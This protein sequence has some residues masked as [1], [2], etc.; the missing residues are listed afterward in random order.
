[1]SK[2]YRLIIFLA[3]SAIFFILFFYQ[4]RISHNIWESLR[5]PSLLFMIYLLLVFIL[6]VVSAITDLKKYS[7]GLDFPADMSEFPSL[8]V[9]IPARNEELNIRRCLES[10]AK[11]EYPN[12]EIIVVDDNSTDRT[13]E[14]I[15]ERAKD[16]NRIKAI[17]AGKLPQGWL[18]KLNALH[19]GIS[20][21]TGEWL[22]MLDADVNLNN[23]AP[24]AAISYC[25]K[26]ELDM[27]SILLN[28]SLN[29][30][31][32]RTIMTIVFGSSSLALLLRKS[33]NPSKEFALASGGFI[34]IKTSSYKA[35]G[36]Y[37]AIKGFRTDDVKLAKLAKANGLKYRFL[38]SQG[39]GS[40]FWYSK[41]LQTWRGWSRSIFAGMEFALGEAV[42]SI[43]RLFIANVLPSIILIYQLIKLFSGGNYWLL[44][45]LIALAQ[46]LV[47]LTYWFYSNNKLGIKA[48]YSLFYPL[49]A[50][51][52]ICIIINSIFQ[53]VF[54]KAV[55]WRERKLSD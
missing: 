40:Q 37:E 39:I 28:P 26:N 52:F 47:L 10:L 11:V 9:I 48:W 46:T 18:G 32:A 53:R 3:V 1:M 44:M 55:I 5:I 30:F 25:L 20:Q 42:Q 22:L 16:D 15:T 2:K 7:I 13:W 23:K 17:K 33:N 27:I 36:G 19:R 29:D 50:F 6:V 54:G 51:V 24:E 8:S 45:L 35:I 4:W 43:I 49:G 38:I 34:L 31:W 21:A 12:M 41:F 14:I